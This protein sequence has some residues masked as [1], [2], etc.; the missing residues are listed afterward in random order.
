MAGSLDI[1]QSKLTT[2][3]AALAGLPRRTT[4]VLGFFASQP[5]GVVAA[6]A[7]RSGPGRSTRC[8]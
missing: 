5:P 1:Y 7:G 4:A 6:R 8:G 2:A 3:E